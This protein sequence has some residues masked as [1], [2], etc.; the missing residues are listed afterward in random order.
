MWDLI[1]NLEIDSFD[2]E[3]TAIPVQDFEG[4]TYIADKDYII[5]T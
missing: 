3:H 1:K 4:K 2:A 5:N